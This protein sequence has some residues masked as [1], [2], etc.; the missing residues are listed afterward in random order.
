MF[1][2]SADFDIPYEVLKTSLAAVE[3][4]KEFK[5]NEGYY[6]PLFK[7]WLVGRLDHLYVSPVFDINVFTAAT[8]ADRS[9]PRLSTLFAALIKA[10][11]SDSV[12]SYFD[13]E[14]MVLSCSSLLMLNFRIYQTSIG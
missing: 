2:F 10:R 9:P 7:R 14:L 1:T 6:W 13:D 11:F 12:L 4:L 8:E 5:F 3:L